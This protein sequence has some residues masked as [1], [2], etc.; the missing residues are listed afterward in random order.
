M[1]TQSECEA[2]WKALMAPRTG[3]VRA[4][5]VAEA[6]EY[7]GWSTDAVLA[8]IADAGERFKAEWQQH[9]TD[10]NDEA[11]VV[12]FYN[13]SE[14]ELF[15][16]I[17]WH[18][19]DPIHY[20]TLMCL[21]VAERRPGR[22]CLD[23]GSGIGSDAIAFAAAG[24]DITL[25]DV[26]EPLLKFAKWRC[27]R[28][29]F[30]VRAIDLKHDAVPERAY[31]AAIC[32]DVLEHIPRPMRT[33]GSISRSLS[34]GGLLFLHA[35]FG[36]DPDRPM[37]VVHDDPITSRMR[38]V[39]FNW[40]GDLEADFPNWL[41]APRVYERFELSKLDGLGY[42]LYDVVMPGPVGSRLAAMYRQ[43]VPRRRTEG[44]ADVR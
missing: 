39:G 18:A 30:K 20:R 25:A 36:E 33:L 44:H 19:T 34:P 26:S 6:A 32:F 31:D 3:D 15:E 10:P 35:P 43:L 13:E 37:H 41:W 1:Y 16:L 22:R 14:S 4:E 11:S 12:R 29:G 8:R 23:F 5:L 28:R 42:Y 17:G 27:E 2:R 21:D 7:F 9:V 38:T 24:F 40:R